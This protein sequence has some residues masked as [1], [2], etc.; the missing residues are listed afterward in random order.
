MNKA[1]KRIH[2]F[3][4]KL[5]K[6]HRMKEMNKKFPSNKTTSLNSKETRAIHEK[7]DYLSKYGLVGNAYDHV[8][9]F[10]KYY[11]GSVDVNLSPSDFYYN[12]ELALNQRWS[13]NF[14]SHK[15]NLRF[16]VPEG[17]RPKTIVYGINEHLYDANNRT[18]TKDAAFEL[19]RSKKD[20][21][22]KQSLF[23]GGGKGVKRFDENASDN[24]ITEI[25][26]TS[27]FI[28]QEVLTQHAFFSELNSSS[29]NTIRM[30]TLNLN[31][32]A[33]VL[34][35]FV[36]IGA[37]GSF[38]DNITGR[39]GMVVGVDTKGNLCSYGLTKDYDKVFESSSR[40]KFEGL[41]I[42]NYEYIKNTVL[43]FHE[44]FPLVNLINWDIAL[45]EEGVV[46]IIEINLNAMNP[47]YHQIFNG[48]I[49][50]ERTQEVI[51]FVIHHSK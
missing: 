32:T 34:S 20:F 47:L 40:K 10:Y 36:R 44:Q 30:E 16:F 13:L 29:V 5:L 12:C 33:S 24:Q 21:V 6:K 26:N 23:T 48:P 39:E 14:L 3:E 41:M 7:W 15:S 46:K 22:V 38:V 49:F 8:F 1:L 43:E 45:D 18:V 9:A 37:K 42:P 35:A 4:N 27:D 25:L 2:N 19:L 50:K 28:V 51:D 31:N 11:H 17:N